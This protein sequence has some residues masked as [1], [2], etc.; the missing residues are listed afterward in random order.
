MKEITLV[1]NTYFVLPAVRAQEEIVQKS[2]LDFVF[3]FQILARFR[4]L[5]TV[6]PIKIQ[7]LNLKLYVFVDETKL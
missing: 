4:F 6:F 2:N 7:C 1:R 5:N 3:V